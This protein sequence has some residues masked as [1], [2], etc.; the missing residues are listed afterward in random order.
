MVK[1]IRE[2]CPN[3]KKPGF[4]SRFF[5]RIVIDSNKTILEKRSNRVKKFREEIKWYLNIPS[6]L[7]W[8]IP[9]IHTYSLDKTNTFIRM[10]YYHHSTLGDLYTSGEHDLKDWER[11]L[12][13][14]FFCVDEMRN[15]QVETSPK[16]MDLALQEMYLEKT[17]SRL[18]K[19]R[20]D[21]LFRKYFENDI[22]INSKEY[23][24]LNYYI[25][26]I[27]GIFDVLVK[28]KVQCFSVIHGDLCL[29]NIF[30]DNENSAI[31]LIDPR[32]KFGEYSIYGDFRYDLAKLS[33]SFN[34]NYEFIISDL[35]E[36]LQEGNQ[37]DYFIHKSA[38]QKSIAGFY[39]KEINRLYHDHVE[40]IDFIES[41]LFL[42]MVPLH[43]DHPKRQ[44]VMLAKGVEKLDKT[45]KALGI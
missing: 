26:K 10:E 3:N 38:N 15:F 40:T 41:V 5:N 21:L 29:A 8:L 36:V 30:F 24:P 32:G 19:L 27:G 6:S 42:S 37:I 39:N 9:K 7:R 44:L 13:A 11:I 16:K 4:N 34:G 18:G 12:G 1:I 22:I 23:K 2:A 17:Y 20:D 45:L 31:K 35:F 25:E 28:G 33:H 14:V 43:A